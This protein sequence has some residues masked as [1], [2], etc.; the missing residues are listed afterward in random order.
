MIVNEDELKV[1]K[2]FG[3]IHMEHQKGKIPTHAT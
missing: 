3:T 2:C 1:W